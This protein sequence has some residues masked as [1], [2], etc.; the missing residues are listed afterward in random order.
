[1]K[2]LRDNYDKRVLFPTH[3]LRFVRTMSRRIG[4]RILVMTCTS[5]K[6]ISAEDGQIWYSRVT[7]FSMC[8]TVEANR[9]NSTV[10]KMFCGSGQSRRTHIRLISRKKQCVQR[11]PLSFKCCCWWLQD[12]YFILILS[13]SISLRV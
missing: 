7:T 12:P 8:I 3:S 4:Q 1:M 2:I 10:G 9:S 13:D 11:L 5:S 6:E